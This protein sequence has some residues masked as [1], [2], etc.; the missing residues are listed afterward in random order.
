MKRILPVLALVF[1][2]AAAWA[3]PAVRYLHVRVDNADKQR[4]VS[5]N[6]PVSVAAQVL[7]AISSGSLHDGRIRVGSFDVN[8]VDVMQ[9]L[10]A[11]KNVP[12]GEFVSI[13]Q[14]G[15][16]VRV[17]K[18]EGD[19]IVHVASNR[20]EGR[21]IDV[22]VPWTVAAALVSSG[23]PHELHLEAAIL[24]LE[25]SRGATQVTVSNGHQRVSIWVDS[26]STMRQ[27]EGGDKQP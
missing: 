12:D 10:G 9:M 27:S 11:L 13:Q 6:L 4:N 19:L 3:A 5:I 18:R 8:G 25:H 26:Q 15:R 7:P 2:A 16:I 17:A 14:P 1:M 22:A 20:G 23:N 24:A 21:I